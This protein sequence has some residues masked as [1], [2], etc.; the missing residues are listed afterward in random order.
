VPGDIYGRALVLQFDIQDMDQKF[1]K[2]KN[3][4]REFKDIID[5][6]GIG[7][8]S[9]ILVAHHPGT[10]PGRHNNRYG[11]IKQADLFFGNTFGFFKKAGVIGGLTTAC[12]ILREDDLYSGVLK[13]FNPCHSGFRIE[14]V[15]KTGPEIIDG[16]RFFRIL[17]HFLN[18]RSQK[19]GVRIKKGKNY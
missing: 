3:P 17:L 18:N 7:K 11:F 4:F 16:F 8:Q 19:S 13:K 10:G 6:R 15:R 2:F 14:H 1:R 5:V 9:G 12:L